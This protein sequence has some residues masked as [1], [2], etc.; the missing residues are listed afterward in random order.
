LRCAVSLAHW[1]SEQG[2]RD[3]GAAEVDSIYRGFNE[4][5]ESADLD[6]ARALLAAA[7]LAS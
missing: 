3:E 5:F 2:R 7:R 1:L 4:G 6:E